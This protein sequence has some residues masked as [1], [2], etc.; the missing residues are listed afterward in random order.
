MYQIYINREICSNVIDYKYKSALLQNT[1]IFPADASSR[2]NVNQTFRT[3]PSEC[4]S[5]NNTSK[6]GTSTECKVLFF[7]VLVWNKDKLKN[8]K[9]I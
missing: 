3:L 8:N 7:F 9:L 1:I 6:I 2:G 5:T 4:T